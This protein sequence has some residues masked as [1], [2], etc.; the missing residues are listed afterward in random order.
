MELDLI[1]RSLYLIFYRTEQS[2]C[3]NDAPSKKKQDGVTTFPNSGAVY[4]I[5]SQCELFGGEGAK[6]CYF[7]DIDEV[8]LQCFFC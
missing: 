2:H 6:G 8:F 5:V 4:D 1:Y 7:G 3:L